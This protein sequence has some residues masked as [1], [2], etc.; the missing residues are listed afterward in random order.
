MNKSIVQYI[1]PQLALLP[2]FKNTAWAQP[3][4]QIALETGVQYGH[5]IPVN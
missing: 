1:H 3:S 2:L 5:L 4:I